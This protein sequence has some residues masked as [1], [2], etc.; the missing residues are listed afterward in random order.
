M[1]HDARTVLVVEDDRNQRDIIKTILVKEGY[2]VEDAGTG[3]KAIELL[4]S[5][6]FDVVL[7]D[8][9]LPDMDGTEILKEVKSQN[10]PCHVIIVTAFGSIP[11]AV[12][13]TRLGAFHYL[14]KPLEKDQLLLVLQ[15]AVDQVRLLKDNIMLKDQLVDKFQLD[16]II[17][18]HGSM[19]ELFKIVRRVAPTNSTVL[20]YGESGTGKELFAKSI[21]YNSPRVQHPFF[22]INCAAIPETLLE[23]ELFGYEKGAFTGAVTR[24]I[25]LF[26]QSNHSTLLLDEIGDL[27][28]AMQAKVLRTIQEKEIRRIGGK[29]TIKLDVRIIAATNKKLEEEI[30]TGRF[31]QDLYYRL[32]V[33]AFTI[34]PLRERMTDIPVLVEHF[35]KR[36][37][38]SHVRKKN[39]SNDA[40]QLLMGYSWPGNVRQ[41][42]SVIER[43]YVMCDEDTIDAEHM[44]EEIKQVQEGQFVQQTFRH[45]MEFII[46]A[47]LTAAEYRL[48]LYLSSLDRLDAGYPAMT[49]PKK[50]IE[51]LNINKDTFYTAVAKLKELGLYDFKLRSG[52][53][54]SPAIP[55]SSEKSPSE[56]SD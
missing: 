38:E 30:K 1:K 51:R 41:L 56:I 2:Y 23:S 47:R 37:N 33:I 11:S 44:P 26:E 55:G 20:I 18:D 28:S 52:Q 50:I 29:E 36:L 16:N 25:G 9:R 12:E 27:T 34:P 8:L 31:R 6:S 14:E 13:A 32:N 54:K 49:E 3:G 22:A 7:T 40:L 10:R 21:H 42:E 15:N 46:D 24:H 45:K 4:K 53:G 5:A 19:R 35:L 48:Y 17:S 43:A 39:M